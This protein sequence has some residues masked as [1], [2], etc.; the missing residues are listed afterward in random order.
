[1]ASIVYGGE[2]QMLVNYRFLGTV[3]DD[4]L[5]FNTNKDAICSRSYI[6]NLF[7]VFFHC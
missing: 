4:K 2:V 7:T 6:K 3:F 1:M 5:K